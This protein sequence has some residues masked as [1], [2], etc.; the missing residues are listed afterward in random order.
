MCSRCVLCD[1]AESTSFARTTEHDR[2]QGNGGT[3]RAPEAI[4]SYGLP[5]LPR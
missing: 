1:T 4:N 5:K 2:K 3:Q